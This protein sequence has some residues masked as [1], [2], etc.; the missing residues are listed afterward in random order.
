MSLQLDIYGGEAEIADVNALQAPF[1]PSQREILLIIR[2]LGSI[3]STQAGKIV[4]AHRGGQLEHGCRRCKAD[5]RGHCDFAA[6]DGRDAMK[7]LRDRGIVRR[8]K[9][10][11]W[12]PVRS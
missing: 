5:S 11:L 9:A 6:S 8:P 7:R 3:T 10:G 1:T 2:Q 12:I 4:H